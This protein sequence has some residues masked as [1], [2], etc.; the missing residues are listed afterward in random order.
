MGL[1]PVFGNT[2]FQIKWF[3][4]IYVITILPCWISVY[5]V[6]KNILGKNL[7]RLLIWSVILLILLAAPY[8]FVLL[9]MRSV[10]WAFWVILL[11]LVS[12][13][14]YKVIIR[15]RTFSVN[16]FWDWYAASYDALLSFTPYT[17]LIQD[18]ASE[19]KEYI[20]PDKIVKILEL[21]CGTGNIASSLE[22]INNV[23]YTGIDA[24]KSMLERAK[25]KIGKNTAFTFIQKNIDDPHFALSGQYDV[26]VI[27]NVLYAIHNH[28]KIIDLVSKIISVDGSLVISE[29]LRNSSIREITRGFIEKDG[30]RAY[31]KVLAHF[32]PFFFLLIANVIITQIEHIKR[33]NFFEEQEL[34]LLVKQCGLKVV[35]TKRVYEKQNILLV[36]KLHIA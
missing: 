23:V 18:V 24:S 15:R 20:R 8:A 36:A 22:A 5:F 16:W 31:F 28:Q 27:N 3:A 12:A 35:S 1:V 13:G 26:V 30:I 19:V 11:I 6:V 2:Q 9:T 4:I 32:F 25:K 33:K 29:P 21:G 7:I 17:A 14:Y 34:F 10:H